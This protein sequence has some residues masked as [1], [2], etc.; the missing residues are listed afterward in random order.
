MATAAADIDDI[1]RAVKERLHDKPDD[2]IEDVYVWADGTVT[3]PPGE[4]GRD[5]DRAVAV[6]SPQDDALADDEIR[7]TIE[8]GLTT[9]DRSDAEPV[10]ERTP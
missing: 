6:F 7:T 3:G 2:D 8:R 1:V 4:A 5:D 10:T 9:V